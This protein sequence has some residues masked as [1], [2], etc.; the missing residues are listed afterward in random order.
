MHASVCA[1]ATTRWPTLR[2]ARTF[3][4]SVSS[5]A[6]PYCLWT[7]GSDASCSSSGT[8]FQPSVPARS[9]SPEC[10]T[11]TT[12]TFS[13]LALSTR[14]AMFAIT[15]SR[16]CASATT[17]FCTSTT[18]NAVLGRSGRVV[19][20]GSSGRTTNERQRTGGE[21]W[22]EH[23]DTPHHRRT[24]NDT[25]RREDTPSSSGSPAFRARRNTIRFCCGGV[26]GKIAG[27]PDR[28]ADERRPE[29]VD[30]D[31]EQPGPAHTVAPEADLQDRG[32][33]GDPRRREDEVAERPRDHA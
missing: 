27:G 14:A 29:A 11:Q 2:S 25:S 10:W 26:A 17:S 7:I 13:A 30:P 9:C 32:A 1:P 21:A 20:A 19:M 5:K 31:R 23:R 8:Y 22:L 6:S 28:S 18:S 15:P 24:R 4:R 16:S 3:S 12:G 33:G